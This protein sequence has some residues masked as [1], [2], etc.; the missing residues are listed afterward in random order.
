MI[1]HNKIRALMLEFHVR[2]ISPLPCADPESYVRGGP[3]LT[4]LVL[5]D[6]RING[7]IIGP[8]AKRHLNGVLLACR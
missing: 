7:A 2:S 4:T 8:A 5:S 1:D 3:T 6:E